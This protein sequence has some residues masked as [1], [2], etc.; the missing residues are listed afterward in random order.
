MAAPNVESNQIAS[1]SLKRNS[2][3]KN[4]A[5]GSFDGI[6][7]AEQ[8]KLEGL[9]GISKLEFD[10]FF[11]SKKEADKPSETPINASHTEP[12]T[13][14]KEA[15]DKALI[16][17]I[18]YDIENTN[19]LKN[20]LSKNISPPSQSV[21]A[22]YA[23]NIMAPTE[24]IFKTDLQITID[25][26]IKNARLVK[27]GQKTELSLTFS[28]KDLGEMLV[29]MIMKNGQVAINIAAGPEAKKLMEKHIDELELALKNARIDLD[30]IKITEKQE[31]SKC[32]T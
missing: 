2:S 1:A 7:F 5:D 25:E 30:S 21:M 28:Y 12:K 26:I 6:L 27:S 10:F 17:E 14:Q 29:S 3:A 20:L 24:L 8:N 13:E 4:T 18:D 15:D 31:G 11:P 16:K 9:F 23:G 19:I 32:L 22:V